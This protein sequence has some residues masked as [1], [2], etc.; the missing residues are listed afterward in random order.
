MTLFFPSFDAYLAAILHPPAPPPTTNSLQLQ[1]HFQLI[2]NTETMNKF[3]C[4]LPPFLTLENEIPSQTGFNKHFKME[5]S[6]GQNTIYTLF[7]PISSLV[8]CCNQVNCPLLRLCNNSTSIR[9]LNFVTAVIH[10][11]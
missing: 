10:L 5:F 9:Q 2:T 1:Q 3:T 7:L 8:V 4:S 6:L 11:A